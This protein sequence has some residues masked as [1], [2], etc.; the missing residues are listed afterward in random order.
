MNWY[1]L[2]DKIPVKASMFEANDWMSDHKNKVVEQTEIGSVFISTVFLGLDHAWG[3]GEPVLFETMVFGGKFDGHQ[4]RYC[5]YDAAEKAHKLM[6]DMV[7]NAFAIEKEGLKKLV[8][9]S[10]N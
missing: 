6:C 1:I 7:L 4:Q 8:I 9:D 3:G 5:S 10:L 2:K